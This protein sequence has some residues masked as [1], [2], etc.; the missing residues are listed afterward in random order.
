MYGC[1]ESVV[2]FAEKLKQLRSK[3]GLT[4]TALAQQCG[5]PL[6]TV[7]NYEQGIREPRWQILFKLAEALGADCR[8]FKDCL[9]TELPVK[10]PAK[11]AARPKRRKGE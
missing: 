1:K 8:V 9:A 7:R 10:P 6:G 3:A 4:Q 11:P 2:Q 5:L